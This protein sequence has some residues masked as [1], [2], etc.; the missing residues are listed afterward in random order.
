MGYSSCLHK[1]CILSLACLA[2]S[3]ID[4][5]HCEIIEEFYGES[6]GAEER[7]SLHSIPTLR[8][9][10]ESHCSHP[11]EWRDRRETSS[12]SCIARGLDR[13]P[14][15]FFATLPLVCR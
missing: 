9:A 14:L 3:P 13:I 5:D 7:D 1:P 11:R 8:A 6:I 4:C 15:D 12:S 2:F 10:L